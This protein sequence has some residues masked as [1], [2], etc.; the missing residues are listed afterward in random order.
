MPLPGHS[1]PD[2]QGGLYFCGNSPD[3]FG[4]GGRERERMQSNKE[5]IAAQEYQ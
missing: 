4:R 3:P 5:F 2:R 1:L